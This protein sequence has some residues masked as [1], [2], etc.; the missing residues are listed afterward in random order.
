M[1]DKSPFKILSIDGG[2]IRGIIPAKI[3]TKLE[4]TGSPICKRFDMIAGTSTG[5]ILTCALLAPSSSNK[6]E[7][8]FSAND[9]LNLYLENGDDIFSIP[10]WKKL[11][12]LGGWRDEKYPSTGIESVLDRYFGDLKLSELLKPSLITAYDIARRECKFFTSHDALS[13]GQDFLIRDVARATSAAPTYFEVAQI[14]NVPSGRIPYPLIDGGLFANNPAMCAYAEA[15]AYGY[16]SALPDNSPFAKVKNGIQVLS[17]GTGVKKEHSYSF[18]EAKDWGPA[19]WIMPVLNIMGSA[20]AEIVHYQLAQILKE[21]KNYFR[22]Q[23]PLSLADS[24]MD[25]ATATNILNLESDA[26]SWISKNKKLLLTI[27][28]QFS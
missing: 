22:V 16:D 13:E 6:G 19:R 7:P 11:S 10:I 28:D 14:F 23:V 21:G 26:E 4:S 24:E 3:L 15:H 18:A 20:S 1:P 8:Q 27:N 25:N 17:L 12:S 5:G 2:G 9:A